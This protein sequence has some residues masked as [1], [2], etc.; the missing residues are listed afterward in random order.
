MKK[1]KANNIKTSGKSGK[2]VKVRSFTPISDALL[3]TNTFADTELADGI[4]RHSMVNLFLKCFGKDRRT[5][6]TPISAILCALLCWPFLK[7]SIHCFCAELCQFIAGGK[8]H[9]KHSNRPEDVLYGILGREDINWRKQSMGTSQSFLRQNDLGPESERA[10]VVDDSI[11]R[12]R[13]KKVEGASK[14]WDHTEQR[15]VF[16]HQVVEFGMAGEK[17]FLPLDRQIYMSSEGA[18]EKPEDK[19][20][21]D[22]RSAAAR[23]MARARGEDKQSMF[24]RMLKSVLRAG[25]KAKYAIADAW[26]G[27]KENI[28]AAIEAGV[29]AVFQMKRGKLKYWVEEQ[30]GGQSYNAKQLYEKHKRKLKKASKGARYKTYRLEAWINLERN[31]NKPE[32]WQKV[33]LVF[34]SPADSSGEN[35]VIFLTTDLESTAEKILEIYALR[36]S[37]EVYF[38]EVKQNF[39]FLA[40]QSSRYQFSYASIHLAAMRYILIFETMLRSGG[41]SYG[42]VRDK[43]SGRLTILSYAGLMWQ[44]FRGLIEGALDQLT[45]LL[46]D[47]VIAKVSDAIDEAV[48]SFLNQA[49]QIDPAQIDGQLYAESIGEL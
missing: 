35:W 2:K 39:G 31:P 26:F 6:A 12:R 22:K 40:E 47:D 18:V 28:E 25:F 24:R 44:L 19:G 7:N 32:R 15:T 23:D 43:Q 20:F 10:F 1:H 11:K 42:E 34:S 36:W 8:D 5:D 33:H 45:G 16:G 30:G 21:R 17:G 9:G 49:L 13:G 38:K 37:I 14:H 29:E 41:L 3:D 27:C 4:K 46:G 48:D